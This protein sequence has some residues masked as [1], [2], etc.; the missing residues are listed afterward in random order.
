VL[1]SQLGLG[2]NVWTSTPS[3]FIVSVVYAAG[4]TVPLH[5]GLNLSGNDFTYPAG[6]P[7][8]PISN[9]L[10]GNCSYPGSLT[11]DQAQQYCLDKAKATL[12]A[13]VSGNQATLIATRSTG[14]T[15]Y[16]GEH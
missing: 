13:N 6:N 4:F 5:T 11:K 1:F 7:L 8:V 9:G 3:N 2:S 10:P 14:S 15:S 16:M 12:G